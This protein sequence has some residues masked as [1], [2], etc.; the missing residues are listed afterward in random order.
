MLPRVALVRTDVL[1]ELSLSFI[2]VTKIPC[3]LN[4]FRKRVRKAVTNK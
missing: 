4:T 1:E 2:R 3:N